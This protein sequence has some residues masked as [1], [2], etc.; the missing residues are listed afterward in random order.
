MN[1]AELEERVSWIVEWTSKKENSSFVDVLNND[2]V[3]AYSVRWK[4]LL[5]IQF[6]G[7]NTCRELGEVLSCC[8]KQHRCTRSVISLHKHETGFPNWVYVYDFT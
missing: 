5:R 2:F 7:A 1:K 8:Y 4:P 3:T 6:Y